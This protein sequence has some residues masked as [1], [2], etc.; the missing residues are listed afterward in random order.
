MR[1]IV[2]TGAN[3]FVGRHVCRML[4]ENGYEVIPVGGPASS[5]SASSYSVDLTRKDE[6]FEE[7]FRTVR[8]Y[9][10]LH[11]AGISSVSKSW[12][13]P[14]SVIGVNTIGAVK[15][16]QAAQASGVKRFIF[17]SSAEIYDPLAG[18]D[19]EPL[20]EDAP[21]N[22]INPYGVSKWSAERLLTLLWKPNLDLIIF[23][24]FNHVG[25]GQSTGFVV[26]DLVAQI[27]SILKKQS[28]PIITAGNLT[29]IRDFLDVRDIARAYVMA[30]SPPV[31][32]GTYNLASGRGRRVE[33]I[34]HALI[35][36]S[37]LDNIQIIQDPNR[38]RPQ[39][40]MVL[41]GNANRYREVSG[42]EPLIPWDRTVHDILVD[43]TF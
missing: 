5:P 27:H 32:P 37:H 20:D 16:F 35:A 17:V 13:M 21:I 42:W 7:F 14:T 41:V 24:P 3:G 43:T 22:P 6:R 39:E 12:R 29:V 34:L 15:L 30:L 11:L 28:P 1:K 8:P 23:R 2:V 25:P 36:Q 4:Q 26:P 31:R 40:R 9:A 18:Q 38:F 10:V 33:D 19:G